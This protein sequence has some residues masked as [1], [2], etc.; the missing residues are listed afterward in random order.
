MNSKS[1]APNP[2]RIGRKE[3]KEL[4]EKPAPFSLCSLCSLAAKT[5]CLLSACFAFTQLSTSMNSKLRIRSPRGIGRKELKELKEKPAPFSLRSPCSLAAKTLC[6]LSACFAYFAVPA[7]AAVFNTNALI[8][9]ANTTFDG[10]DIIISGA[11][12]PNSHLELRPA[13][14]LHGSLL[15]TNGAVLTHSPCSWSAQRPIS[16]PCQPGQEL[17][18]RQNLNPEGLLQHPQVLVLGGNDLRPAGQSA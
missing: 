12:F 14:L 6:L 11:T 15:L 4:K 16:I 13:H 7:S 17:A 10:Q 2:K 9:E 3:L 1:E 5:L 8:S 18:R